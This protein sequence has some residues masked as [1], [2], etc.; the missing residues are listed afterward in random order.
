MLPININFLHK[1]IFESENN[2]ISEFSV[3]KEILPLN[4]I[5]INSWFLEIIFFTIIRF[6]EF[7]F[8]IRWNWQISP[9][10]WAFHLYAP[11]S[12]FIVSGEGPWYGLPS[13]T[14]IHIFVSWLDTFLLIVWWLSANT[15]YHDVLLDF[16]EL[17]DM[18]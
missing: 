5:T 10:I 17:W 3:S 16:S 2:K 4:L 15:F 14:T 1:H 6:Q 18:Q 12:P 7:E 11:L 8:W 13:E 9:S